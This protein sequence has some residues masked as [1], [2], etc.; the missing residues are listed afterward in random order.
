MITAMFVHFKVL[1]LIHLEGLMKT[2]KSHHK[3]SSHVLAQNLEA[4]LP[5]L[6]CMV[7]D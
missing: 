6:T 4:L 2:V 3:G 1:S 5:G 7:M